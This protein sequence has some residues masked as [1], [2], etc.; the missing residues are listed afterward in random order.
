[1]IKSKL[2]LR[3]ENGTKYDRARNRQ[4]WS[5]DSQLIAIHDENR[6]TSLKKKGTT[7]DRHPSAITYD[8]HLADFNDDN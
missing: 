8:L 1:M 5:N 7:N 2:P 3:V 6:T 4:Q